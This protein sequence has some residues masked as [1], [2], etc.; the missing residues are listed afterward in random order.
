M[1][2]YHHMG[3]WWFYGGSL[4]MILF[5]VLIGIAVYFGVKLAQRPPG[6]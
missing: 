4:M 3:G 5:V 1:Y 2:G 6:S